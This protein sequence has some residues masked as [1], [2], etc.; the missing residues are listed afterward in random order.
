MSPEFMKLVKRMGP[1]R[2]IKDPQGMV[3]KL[4][5]LVCNAAARQASLT[6]GE[7]WHAQIEFLSKTTPIAD[8]EKALEPFWREQGET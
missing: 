4:N 1:P 5:E 6:N 8:V 7:G 2:N 3:S